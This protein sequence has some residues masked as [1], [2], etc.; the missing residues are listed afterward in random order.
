MPFLSPVS[1]CRHHIKISGGQ[2]NSTKSLSGGNRGYFALK[3]GLDKIDLIKAFFGQNFENTRAAA[4]DAI[5]MCN[6]TLRVQFD[7]ENS[8]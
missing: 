1:A 4:D 3:N 7:S 8:G 6:T 5:T 2:T